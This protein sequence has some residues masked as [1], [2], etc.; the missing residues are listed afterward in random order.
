MDGEARKKLTP[1]LA[2][3]GVLAVLAAI[4]KFGP[5]TIKLANVAPSFASSADP[6]LALK[7]PRQ[8]VVQLLFAS[9]VLAF[10][11]GRFREKIPTALALCL[12]L[13]PLAWVFYF[14]WSLGENVSELIPARKE[15]LFD[16]NVFAAAGVTT[17]VA[18]FIPRRARGIGVGILGLVV[19]FLGMCDILSMRIFGNVLPFASHGSILQ[20]WDARASVAALFEKDDWWIAV[21]FATSVAML[22]LWRVKKIDGLLPVR[23]ATYILPAAALGYYFVPRVQADVA[24]FL[25][26]KYAKDVLNREDQVW[27]AGF[28]EAHIRE[29]SLNT[30]HWLAH[31]QPTAA[32]LVEVEKYYR[33]EHAAY[34]TADRPS[35]GKFKGKNVLVLQIEAFEE[36]L[37]GAKVNGQEITPNLNQ[38]RAQGLFYDNI[39]NVVASSSTAD[40]EYLFL[41]S[42]HPL[43]DGAVAFRREENHFV[44]F[45]TTLRDAGYSTLSMHGYARGMWNRAVLH[46]KYGFTHSLF[47]EELGETPKVGWG[48]DDHAFFQ[49]LVTQAKKE[50]APWFVYAITLSSHHPYN[51]IPYNRRRLKLGPLENTMVGNY[52]HAASFADD[53]LGQLFRDLRTA[54]LLKDTVVVMYGDHEGHLEASQRD[55]TNLASQTNIP[56]WKTDLIGTGRPLGE[57]WWLNRIPLLILL[58]GESTPQTIRAVGAQLDFAPTVLHYLGVDPPRSFV[59]HAILPDDVGGFVARWDGS[60]VAPPLIFD[61]VLNECRVMSDLRVVPPETC[62][63]GADR[64]RRE[65]DMSWLVTNNDLARRLVEHAQPV[66]PAPKPAPPGAPLGGACQDEKDCTGPQGFDTH[67]LGGLCVTDPHG[68][69]DHPGST[70]PCALGSACYSM[71]ADLNVC[72]A[73]CDVL[74]CAGQCND[75]GLCVPRPQ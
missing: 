58:P 41:N 71:S 22:V 59:G 13:L 31:K 63:A 30:K 20:L 74:A 2:L 48:L 49:K 21:Y 36:W 17:M 57:P 50:P 12:D 25:K 5:L 52:I 55:R 45:A 66:Q 67:C 62:R 7:S 27:R 56:K 72:A 64:A 42:N 9:L 32:E 6:T 16:R 40:C 47:A 61:A 26:S 68:P 29:I 53:A 51:D 18:A 15:A 37:I 19:A 23:I 4:L 46:P 60:F 24:E 43:S 73:V 70:K 34:Y 38:I 10:V 54:D 8:V 1:W 3:A 39:F 65:V 44:T 69:C 11:A 33:D 35:F 75:A 14:A 28:L